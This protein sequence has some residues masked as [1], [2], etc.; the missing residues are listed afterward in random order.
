MKS[1]ISLR[2]HLLDRKKQCERMLKRDNL[3][4]K[5]LEQYWRFCREI[6]RELKAIR[7]K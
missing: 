1:K 6:D 2:Q 7:E 5:Q 4:T 3:P